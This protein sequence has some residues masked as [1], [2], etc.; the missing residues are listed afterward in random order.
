MGVGGDMGF[1]DRVAV[2]IIN[3]KLCYVGLVKRMMDRYDGDSL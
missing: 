1:I 2:V 3:K